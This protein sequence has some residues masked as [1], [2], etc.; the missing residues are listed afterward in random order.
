MEALLPL[1]IAE[2]AKTVPALAIDIIQVLKNEGS[3]EDWAA[4]R[5]KWNR[6]ADSFFQTPPKPP[7]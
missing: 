7:A 3:E 6:P 5:A 1:I 4:L 2:L